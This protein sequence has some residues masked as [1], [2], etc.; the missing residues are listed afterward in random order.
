MRY[1]KFAVCLAEPERA[2]LRTLI[3]LGI[4][5]AWH[6]THARILL[7]ADQSEEARRG[8]TGPLEVHSATVS[9]VCRTYVEQGLDTALKRKLPDRVCARRLYEAAQAGNG[10]PYGCWSMIWSGWRSSRQSPT[11][12]FGGPLNKR[13]QALAKRVVASA[14]GG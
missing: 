3:I 7:E 1:A 4:A 11:K 8:P 2:R 13:P 5:P 14:A 6:S 12:R 10:G 9:R